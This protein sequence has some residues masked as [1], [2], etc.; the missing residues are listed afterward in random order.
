ML[1]QHAEMKLTIEGHSDS[2]GTAS[3]NERLS[4]MRATAVRRA[5]IE[6]RAG[7]EL[8]AGDVLLIDLG[9]GGFDLDAFAAA[10]ALEEMPLT[11]HYFSPKAWKWEAEVKW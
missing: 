3:M 1:A 4:E 6:P 11:G 10:N 5:L 8:A 2:T 9:E 7:T